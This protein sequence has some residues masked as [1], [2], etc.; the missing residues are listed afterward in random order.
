ML[1]N[2]YHCTHFFHDPVEISFAVGSY[3]VA[4]ILDPVFCIAKAAAAAI[5]QC[6]QRTIAE[7]AIEFA[8]TYALMAGKVLTFPILEKLIM[9]HFLL[10]IPLSTG[11]LPAADV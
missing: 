4:A 5:T 1:C 3:A 11:K 7:Q 2:F 8:L 9:F 10:L 6:I